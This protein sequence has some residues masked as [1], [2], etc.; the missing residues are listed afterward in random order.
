MSNE[1]I[2][3]LV[4]GAI[5]GFIVAL[6]L[7]ALLLRRARTRHADEMAEFDQSII[8][9]RQ[10]RAEDKET[11][12]RL[13][14]ELATQTPEHLREVAQTAEL[15]RDSAVSER[16]QALE[17]LGLVQNALTDA[18]ERVNDRENKLMEYRA[19]LRDIRLSLEEQDRFRRAVVTGDIPATAEADLPVG[20]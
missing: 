20:D 11:N 12:R 7:G 4:I 18:N 15:E 10:E 6:L 16:D 17:Q 19:Q 3:G 14:Y 5:A 2:T 8:D 13:R 1:M 9:L